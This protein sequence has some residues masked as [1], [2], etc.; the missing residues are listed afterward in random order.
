MRVLINDIYCKEEKLRPPGFSLHLT[1]KY[2]SNLYKK[3]ND[4]DLF[5]MRDAQVSNLFFYILVERESDCFYEIMVK[6]VQTIK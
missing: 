1:L 2:R 4:H 5:N 6:V 3:N